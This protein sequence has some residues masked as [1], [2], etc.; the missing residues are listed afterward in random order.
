MNIII[1]EDEGYKNFGPLTLTRPA[2]DLRCGINTL[3]EKIMRQYPKAKID[4]S[5]RY[6]LPGKKVMKFEKGLFING[7]ILAPARLAREIPLKGRDEVFY[8]GDE[9]VAIRAVSRN[10]DQVRKRS[11]VKRTKIKVVK[12]PWDLLAENGGQ[13]KEDKRYLRGKGKSKGKKDKTVVIYN[14]KDVIIDQGA[15]VEAGSVIDARTGPVYIGKGAIIKPLTYL[16]GPLSIGAMCRIGGEVSGSIFHGFSNKQHYG[17][18]GSSYIG[19]WVNLGAGTTNSNLKNNYGS[20]RVVLEGKPVDSGHKFVGCFVA[21]H[22][23]TGIGTLITTGAVIGVGAN[24]FGGGVTPK[25]VASFA[26]GDRQKYDLEKAIKAMKEIMRR[27]DKN[28]NPEQER[29]I[30]YLYKHPE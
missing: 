16:K 24:I 15:V 26:W 27:R 29:L 28:F 6:Y 9:I 2:Y 19:E 4:F 17:F 5:C 25:V 10:F 3:A 12:F 14:P 7:R 13:I 8:S 20:V 18:I 22:V 23:K 21:D 1:Y 11:K 30:R